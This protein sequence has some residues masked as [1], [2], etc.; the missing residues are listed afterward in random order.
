MD[1]PNAM[2]RQIIGF[3]LSSA[4]ASLAVF[5][6]LPFAYEGNVQTYWYYPIAFVLVA[7]G[8]FRLSISK[9]KS[10]KW[11]WLGLPFAAGVAFS[12]FYLALGVDLTL[13]VLM[14]LSYLLFRS[15]MMTTT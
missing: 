5:A 15:I 4:L 1:D 6:P 3:L 14:L 13:C 10:A 11:Y 9:C 12:V 2:T 7:D 8:A